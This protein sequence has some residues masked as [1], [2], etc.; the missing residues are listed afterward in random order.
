MDPPRTISKKISTNFNTYAHS[1][2]VSGRTTPHMMTSSRKGERSRPMSPTIARP[3]Y[4]IKRPPSAARVLEAGKRAPS[5]FNHRPQTANS[6]FRPES[7]MS[8]RSVQ[9][10]PSS[11]KGAENTVVSVR[12]R[13]AEAGSPWKP[14]LYSDHEKTIRSS[15]KMTG[16][17]LDFSFDN[18]F[19]ETSTNAMVYEASVKKLVAGVLDGFHGTVFAYGMT[20]TGKTY[21]MQ[22]TSESPGIIPLAV[23]DIFNAIT[24]DS[25]NRYSLRVSYLEIYNEKIRDLLSRTLANNDEIKIRDDPKRG[26]HAYPLVEIPVTSTAAFLDIMAQGDA[27]RHSA[28]TDF[29]AHSSRSHAVVQIVVE[30]VPG[31]MS[32]QIANVGGTAKVSTLNL[33]DLAGS[34]RAASDAER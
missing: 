14:W 32:T 31:A 30:S 10:L 15:P 34:E 1:P 16:P 24:Q 3:Q 28:A 33:I 7:S 2:T 17:A 23:Q 11:G 4:T 12:I 13:P 8:I 5:P 18:V 6:D 26:I 22:G 25:N 29:N 27:L 19:T 21:S 9:S 20:G